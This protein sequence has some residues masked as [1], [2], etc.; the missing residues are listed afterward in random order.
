MTL[1]KGWWFGDGLASDFSLED[2]HVVHELLKVA[3][4]DL[5]AVSAAA[6]QDQQLYEGDE[7]DV[8]HFRLAAHYLD[9][10]VLLELNPL[11]VGVFEEV[12]EGEG[13]L[14]VLFNRR[15][16]HS[17]REHVVLADA[18]RILLDQ[19]A[20]LDNEELI[21]ELLKG[22]IAALDCPLKGRKCCPSF[23][24][25][26]GA[27]RRHIIIDG[28]CSAHAELRLRVRTGHNARQGLL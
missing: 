4:T 27:A 14:P 2:V 16:A 10:L 22:A 7:S 6:R 12:F 9:D 3:N 8:A 23:A 11:L 24:L 19:V 20:F 1:N 21:D 25:L 13:L 28:R 5:G 15:L 17:L 26:E 18:I